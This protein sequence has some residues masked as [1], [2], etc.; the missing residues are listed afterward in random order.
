MSMK[1]HFVIERL[2]IKKT[3]WF[4]LCTYTLKILEQFVLLL[5][6]FSELLLQFFP[7]FFFLCKS[8]LHLLELN[9]RKI[10]SRRSACHFITESI[11]ECLNSV[12]VSVCSNN[13]ICHQ[14]CEWYL[15][16][17]LH[18]NQPTFL[19]LI[20]FK[21]KYYFR[22]SPRFQFHEAFPLPLE[23]SC[24]SFVYVL[25]FPAHRTRAA[26]SANQKQDQ[27]QLWFGAY[28]SRAWQ[29]R[30]ITWRRVKI[31]AFFSPGVWLKYL[32]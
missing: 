10:T 14:R 29:P 28:F 13:F 2:V 23:K 26:V 1:D 5:H 31:I 17:G 18:Y 22:S 15:F 19:L 20:Q 21:T 16:V 3:Q 27:D 30:C 11:Y 8:F 12:Q 6:E 25:N 4:L 32:L 24:V 9:N 7:E